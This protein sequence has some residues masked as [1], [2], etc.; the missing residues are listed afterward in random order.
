MCVSHNRDDVYVLNSGICTR[1]YSRARKKQ[2][3]ATFFSCEKTTADT[4]SG[5]ALQFPCKTFKKACASIT[6]DK[7][8]FGAHFLVS[9]M[10]RRN[11][12][13]TE[14]N[15]RSGDQPQGNKI[16]NM[17][18]LYPQWRS[19]L[20]RLV[21]AVLFRYQLFVQH[22]S[23][24]Y[25]SGETFQAVKKEF[26]NKPGVVARKFQGWWQAGGKKTYLKALNQKRQTICN[27][28]KGAVIGTSF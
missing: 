21:S 22:P 13:N 4:V 1:C 25:L 15:G 17:S 11:S 8:N 27:T 6:E 28:L 20:R 5:G 16:V 7:P 19:M 2:V 14:P 10:T 23:E 24:L 26:N 12:E 3:R 9:K 18:S